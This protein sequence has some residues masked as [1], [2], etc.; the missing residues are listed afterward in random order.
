[1]T[2][3]MTVDEFVMILAVAWLFLMLLVI[4]GLKQ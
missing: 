4:F 3:P 2:T 1:M